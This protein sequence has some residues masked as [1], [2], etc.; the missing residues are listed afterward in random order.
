MLWA[1]LWPGLLMEFPCILAFACS[2]APPYVLEGDLTAHR[3]LR[4]TLAGPETA[5]RET[6]N[7]FLDYRMEVVF[8]HEDGGA[9]RVSG[10]FAADGRAADT[11]AEQGNRWRAYFLPDRPGRWSFQVSLRSGPRIA[12]RPE[13]EGSA[14]VG[15]GSSGE[16]LVAPVPEGSSE[17]GLLRYVGHRYLQFAGSGAW[18]LKAG[19]DSPENFLAYAEFDWEDPE[20][21]A[22][23]EAR[24][25]EAQPRPRHRY[26]PHLG[27]WRPG[28][29]TWGDTE[30]GKGIIGALNYLAAQGVNSVYFLTMNIGGDGDDVWPYLTREDRYR[31][32]CSRLDQWNRVFDHMDRLGIALHVVLTETENES[33]FEAEEGGTFAD[34]RKL[35]YRELVARFAH[36]PA[37]VWNLGE[38]NGWDDAKE[39]EE[40]LPKNRGNGDEQR[41]AF[42]S[43]L[44][45]LDPYDHPIVV[46]TLPG[47]YDEIYEPL[48]G[49]PNFDG[50]SLQMVDM[51]AT[52][53]ETRKWIERS[54]E[55]G[56]PWVVTLDEIGPPSDGVLPDE[57]DP[58]H[59]AVRQHALWGNLMAGGGGCEWYFGYRYPHNDL[60]LEDFR[61]RENMWKQ[62]RIA[63]EFFQRH[64]PFW[65]M[66]PCDELLDGPGY[67]LGR[68]EGPWVVYLPRGT[69]GTRIELPEGVY[70]MS[71]WDPRNG[72]ELIPGRE[73]KLAA[74]WRLR[75]ATAPRDLEKDW[76]VLLR[77]R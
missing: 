67:C 5:E 40:V 10:F 54:R 52:H 27:D 36:H 38:E 49:T 48:L 30:R 8:R 24:R 7:P 64:L 32:D 75:L 3:V 11:G 47:R 66:E 37:L 19:A 42:A 4:L 46:H 2:P 57:V 63:V 56:R 45:E 43:Y 26:A 73:A 6:P 28:D 72:G 13:E 58:D 15:D 59:D 33:L 65:E 23:E 62:T 34:S 39:G 18:F 68:A 9:F 50:A 55:A 53:A 29:P 1:K 74:G 20:R 16:F 60:G 35:Y 17:R 51:T 12:V 76:V 41:L 22:P 70:A 14:A 69:A 44:R 77:R 25:D 31:F 61:S 21:V 71:W